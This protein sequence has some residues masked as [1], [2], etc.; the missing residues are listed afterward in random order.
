M[1]LGSNDTDV[2]LDFIFKLGD[3]LLALC[4]GLLIEHF[5]LYTYITRTK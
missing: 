4:Q 1:K 2:S 5:L 3:Y